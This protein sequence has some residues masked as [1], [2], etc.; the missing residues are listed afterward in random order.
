MLPDITG[1]SA[2][3]VGL[4]CDS[5]FWD[6]SQIEEGKDYTYEQ[7]VSLIKDDEGTV[8][9]KRTKVDSKEIQ[10][11]AWGITLDLEEIGEHAHKSYLVKKKRNFD[12]NTK[13][14][15]SNELA[16]DF[17]LS[18]DNKSGLIY[19]IVLF[20]LK[21]RGRKAWR[22]GEPVSMMEFSKGKWEVEVGMVSRVFQKMLFN[23][24]N[25][26]TQSILGNILK[27]SVDEVKKNIFLRALEFMGNDPDINCQVKTKVLF[28]DADE[29]ADTELSDTEALAAHKI[30][31]QGKIYDYK[32]AYANDLLLEMIGVIEDQVLSEMKFDS[33]REVVAAGKYPEY[34]AAVARRVSNLEVSNF[35]IVKDKEPKR[36]DDLGD[37]EK[38]EGAEEKKNYKILNYWKV[39]EISIPDES[40]NKRIAKIIAKNNNIQRFEKEEDLLNDQALLADYLTMLKK[41]LNEYVEGRV[42]TKVNLADFDFTSGEGEKLAEELSW[43][44]YFSKYAQYRIYSPREWDSFLLGNDEEIVEKDGVKFIFDKDGAISGMIDD[45]YNRINF[46]T[47]E[48]DRDGAD[49]FTIFS[50]LERLAAQIIN[51]NKSLIEIKDKYTKKMGDLVQSI[52][53]SQQ[54]EISEKGLDLNAM[55][56]KIKELMQTQFKPRKDALKIARK[57]MC[58]KKKA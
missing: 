50:A 49:D 53:L 58:T 37:D 46:V 18:R 35:F 36:K 23:G 29:G 27:L 38:N 44:S 21:I 9:P 56:D 26:L 12:I 1:R 31:Y 42:G 34:R 55:N 17:L 11:E 22:R 48:V 14:D 33:Q 5:L 41:E 45:T 4:F 32:S 24:D 8:L 51:E 16:Q 19:N 30:K 10:F 2:K 28:I 15:I 39:Y 54:G 52:I 57:I 6:Y 43:I 3:T 20:L 40:L 7:L 13:I 25:I 47:G